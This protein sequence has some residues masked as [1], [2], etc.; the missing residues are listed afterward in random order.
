[1]QNQNRN[2]KIAGLLTPIALAATQLFAITAYAEEAK[3]T[4]VEVV[5]TTPLAGIGVPKEQIAANVQTATGQQIEDSGAINLADFMAQNMGGVHINDN[6]GNPY[7]VDL[8]YRGYTASPQLGAPQGISVY[9]DGVRM[10]Q[11]FGDVVQWDLI[12]KSAIKNITLIPGSNPL[13]GLNTLGGAISIQTKDGLSYQGTE[14]EAGIGGY[15]RYTSEFETGGKNDQGLNWYVNASRFGED[16]WRDASPSHLNQLFS[17]LGWKDRDTE[18][19]LT[20]ALSNSKLTGNGLQQKE[21]LDANYKSVYTKPDETKGTSNFLNLELKRNLNENALFSGN[22]YYKNT[23]SHTFNGDVND[24]SFMG[25]IYGGVYGAAANSLNGIV[26]YGS[27]SGRNGYFATTNA[28]NTQTTYNNQP[29][30]FGGGSCIYQATHASPSYDGGGNITLGSLTYTMREPNE[31]CTGLIN[32]TSTKQDSYGL[33]GALNF[34]HSLTFAKSNTVIGTALDFSKTKYNQSTQFGYLTPDRSVVGVNAYADGTQYSENAY[35]NRVDLSSSTKSASLF[36]GNTLSFVEDTVHVSSALR[37]NTTRISNQDNLYPYN[38]AWINA[39]CDA[40]SGDCAQ[41]NGHNANVRGSLT[42]A[43]RYSRLNPA[44]GVSLTP[45]S[46]FNSYL[47]YSESSRAPTSIE[48]GCADPYFG[49]RLPNSMAGDPHLKQVVAKTW[50][51]GARGK[52][53]GRQWFWNTA[54]Y[55]ANNYDDIMFVANPNQTGTGYFKNFGK[56]RREGLELGLA[57]REGQ[58][59]FGA[60]YSYLKSTYR[61]AEEISSPYNSQANSE[62]NITINPGNQIPLM[63]NHIFNFKIGY[64][65][66]QQFKTSLSLFGVGSSYLRGNE[67]NANAGGNNGYGNTT[68]YNAEQNNGSSTGSG[69]AGQSAK[70]G[71]LTD[72]AN[73]LAGYGIFNWSATYQPE[74]RLSF[75]ATVM[76]LFDKKYSTSGQLGPQAFNADGSYTNGG[77]NNGCSVITSG[78]GAVDSAC[79]GSVFYSPGAPRTFW[80][81]MRYTFDKPRKD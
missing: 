74:D 17:K 64:K 21:L 27:N 39:Y 71:V 5:A 38:N 29:M 1:M 75:T 22:A 77:N 7:G 30:N 80:V 28:A 41:V 78:N 43:H 42:E 45:N 9:M 68:T 15:G 48:L 40:N 73:K 60:N 54:I 26:S 46:A 36:G 2:K 3:L 79:R 50:E 8:N 19:K 72:S 57:G 6:V 4:P 58:F 56:T 61:S 69:A 13:F 66:N 51:L 33:S 53:E 65:V 31:K 76:N 12:P 35:D 25:S 23:N 52:I 67:N 34:E 16:G 62:G 47:S 70:N 10:N 20:Y 59:S 49:C 44:V 63:P 14:F 37:F 32:Q 18:L 55:Q 11:P 24:D 81:S